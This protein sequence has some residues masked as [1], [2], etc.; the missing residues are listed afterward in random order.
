MR[1]NIPT[2]PL[3]FSLLGCEV[4]VSDDAI[5]GA[6]ILGYVQ[7]NTE[8]SKITFMPSVLGTALGIPQSIRETMH[9][10]NS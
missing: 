7:P 4:V 2:V 10:S 8:R 6:M 5:P 3:T 1:L 9:D